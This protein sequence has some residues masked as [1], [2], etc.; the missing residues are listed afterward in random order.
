MA[1]GLV[2]IGI[3]VGAGVVGVVAGR[4]PKDASKTRIR[5]WLESIMANP[6]IHQTACVLGGVLTGTNSVTG[7]HRFGNIGK[8]VDTLV[9]AIGS[10]QDVIASSFGAGDGL[11]AAAA[12]EMNAVFD[13]LK[14][15]N[16]EGIP[17]HADAEV[18]TSDVEV[19]QKLLIYEVDS[20]K[21]YRIDS[22]VPK[23]RTWNIRGYLM[24]NARTVPM[25][26]QLVIKPSLIAQR[27]L[28]QWFV[29]SRRPVMYKTH[30]NRFYT[31]LITHFDSQYTVQSL[32]ALAVN[33]SL[34]EFKVMQVN[35][36]NLNTLMSKTSEVF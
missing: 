4:T 34:Q 27:K 29:D 18:E 23:P 33:I 30:D 9:A 1:I 25:E 13:E 5:L 12:K 3:A 28:L 32:N 2:G 15:P 11:N 20:N 21:D 6:P 24:S 16:I 26:S 35:Q 14:N 7:I 17:I 19:S 31:C 8:G 10:A 22:S 36:G